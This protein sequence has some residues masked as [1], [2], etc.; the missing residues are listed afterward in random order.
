[1]NVK[2]KLVAVAVAAAFAPLAAYATNGYF[3]HGFGVKAQGMGGVGIA[4]P[5]DSIAAG[6]NPAG[7]ALRRRP[8]RRRPDL[9]PSRPRGA[10]HR[11]RRPRRT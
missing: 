11:Q 3:T 8:L 2:S 9:V 7:M 4:L 1:M 10:D 6:A 5:Q